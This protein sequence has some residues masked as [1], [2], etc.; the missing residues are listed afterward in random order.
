MPF[1]SKAAYARHRGCSAAAVTY[2]AKEGRITVNAEGM[3]DPE[4]ADQEWARN[5]RA[6]PSNVNAPPTYARPPA[7]P[8]PP[9]AAPPAPPPAADPIDPGH[10]PDY[11]ESRARRE[12]A[13]ADL[14]EL[15]VRTQRGE[16]VPAAAVRA[17]FSR[18]MASIRDGL[19]N[20]PARLAPVV[21]AESNLGKVQALIDGELRAVLAQLIEGNT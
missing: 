11:Q 2:A 19:L 1:I 6:R 10:V 3:I 4:V 18:Q 16:L 9:E 14:A 13:E 12:A 7:P 17:E 15:K 8:R 20:I 21:A 5:S